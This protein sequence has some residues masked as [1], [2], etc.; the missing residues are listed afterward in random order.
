MKRRPK[1]S[2]TEGKKDTGMLKY[3]RN[4]VP[5][6]SPHANTCPDSHSVC[7]SVCLSVCLFGSLSIRPSAC[8]C[9]CPSA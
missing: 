3:I 9:L 4:Q 1:D 8:V 2:N 6:Y 7:Q 5:T